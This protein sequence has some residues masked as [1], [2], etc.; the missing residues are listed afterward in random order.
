M[1]TIYTCSIPIWN[2]FMVPCPFV[3]VA[4][5]PVYRFLRRKVVWYSYLL[6]NFPQSVVIH[7]IKGF[8]I[9]NEAEV[10]IFLELPCFLQKMLAL[11]SLVSLPLWNPPCF[12]KF[13]VHVLLKPSL[14]DFEHN[15]VSMWN[16]SNCMVLW[17]FFWHC[18]SLGLEWKLIFSSPVATAEFSKFADILNAAL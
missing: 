7:T 5:W 18:P 12:W 9:V 11:W 10:D 8:S 2:Q 14:K 13:T 6:K 16:D 17:T 1:G 4:S 15:L 3:T